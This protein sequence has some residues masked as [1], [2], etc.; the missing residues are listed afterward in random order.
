MGAYK[1]FHVGSLDY[2]PNYIPGAL[3]VEPPGKG[4]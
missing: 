2:F 1:G 3:K 4:V